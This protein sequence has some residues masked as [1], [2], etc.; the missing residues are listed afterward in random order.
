M[1]RSLGRRGRLRVARVAAP[2][3]GWIIQ[4]SRRSLLKHRM[5]KHLH[6]PREEKDTRCVWDCV[7]DLV[8][9]PVG[10]VETSRQEGEIQ[11]L[12]FTQNQPIALTAQTTRTKPTAATG[13]SRK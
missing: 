5:A 6:Q 2:T 7:G 8:G 1:H 9:C 4:Q 12:E 10:S 11:Q 13:S 3:L